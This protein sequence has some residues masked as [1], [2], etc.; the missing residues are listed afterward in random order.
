M[1]DGAEGRSD[2][3][4]LVAVLEQLHRTVLHWPVALASIQTLLPAHGRSVCGSA[5]ADRRFGA[6]RTV[7][8][9]ILEDRGNR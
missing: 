7:L 1:Q 4:R 6:A 2:Q 9:S 5:E 8:P 3:S